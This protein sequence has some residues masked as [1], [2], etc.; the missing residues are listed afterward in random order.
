M[1]SKWVGDALVKDGMYLS[2]SAQSSATTA[3]TSTGCA[4]FIFVCY[5]CASVCPTLYLVP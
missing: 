4:L 5:L 1:I 3:I 2:Y